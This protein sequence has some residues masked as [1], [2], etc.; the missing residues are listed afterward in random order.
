MGVDGRCRVVALAAALCTGG[1]GCLMA[2]ESKVWELTDGQC[3]E[4]HAAA[5]GPRHLLLLRL[6]LLRPL[7]HQFCDELE[8]NFL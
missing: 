1:D 3:V 6:L 2:V 7:G 8:L 5:A 4:H